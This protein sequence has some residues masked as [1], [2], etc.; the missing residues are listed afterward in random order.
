MQM[1]F[2]GICSIASWK[3]TGDRKLFT[4]YADE[5]CSAI[6]EVQ[7][8]SGMLVLIQREVR[9]FGFGIIRSNDLCIFVAAFA[10]YLLWKA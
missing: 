5:L 3:K 2:F 4:W 9:F 8:D 1:A 7:S 6:D 10:I